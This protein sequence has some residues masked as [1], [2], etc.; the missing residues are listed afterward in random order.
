MSATGYLKAMMTGGS[1]SRL[2]LT[3]EDLQA[4]VLPLYTAPLIGP[5]CRP[6]IAP[7]GILAQYLSKLAYCQGQVILRIMMML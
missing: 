6:T 1:I 5:N 2:G 3:V 4:L 7:S